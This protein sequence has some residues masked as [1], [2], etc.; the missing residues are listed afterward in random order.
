MSV[1]CVCVCVCV[2]VRVCARVYTYANRDSPHF[3]VVGKQPAKD[4][5]GCVCHEH[6]TFKG[7]LGEHMREETMAS[8][9]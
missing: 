3:D 5:L 6:T 1:V 2:C 7:S 4:G 9:P 8:S